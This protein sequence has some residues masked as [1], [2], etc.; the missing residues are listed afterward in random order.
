MAKLRAGSRVGV[1][2][3]SI[4]V[5]IRGDKTRADDGEK[6][7]DPG[8]GTFQESHVRNSQTYEEILATDQTE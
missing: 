1:D 2:A 6:Q 5:D 7:Q 4:V 8:L 3:V